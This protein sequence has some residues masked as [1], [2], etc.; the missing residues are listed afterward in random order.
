MNRKGMSQVLALIIAASVL[1]MTAL[2]VIFM[3]NNTAGQTSNQANLGACQGTIQSICSTS[4]GTDYVPATC[5]GLENKV[6]R[7]ND[8]G[9]NCN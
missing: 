5:Q 2:T 8:N 4:D 3:V 1:M 6:S 7:V 9:V